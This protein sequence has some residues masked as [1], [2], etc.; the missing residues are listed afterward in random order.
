MTP[1]IAHRAMELAEVV[2]H[3]ASGAAPESASWGIAV[4]APVQ[5]TLN[6]TPWTVVLATPC[7]VEDL[8]VGLVLTERV[9]TDVRSVRS[10]T[11]A[12][13]LHDIAVDVVVPEDQIDRTALQHRSLIGNSACGLCGIESLAQLQE[14]R[15][16]SESG[17]DHASGGPQS[18]GPEIS[19]SAVLAAF[20]ALPS[21]QA[22]NRET[23]SMH[24]AA[25][26]E[27]GGTILLARED[28]GRHNALDKLIGALA[29][30]DMLVQPG[31][32][33][34]SS[35]CSYELVYKASVANTRLLATISAPTSMA[36]E[37]S[38]ALALPIACRIGG[39]ADGRVVH[40]R[41]EITSAR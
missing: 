9:L 4:E 28:V 21:H 40:F 8:A 31:F 38:R 6:G 18:D 12:E 24:A 1:P 32:V 37:W 26:C 23:H 36:L 3:S 5:V 25:W 2:I 7:D 14:R 27:P 22:V 39:P 10:V 17:A 11:A 16:R 33:V 34:L 20:A 29:R 41:T 15:T 30:R 35:R 19:D 13:F